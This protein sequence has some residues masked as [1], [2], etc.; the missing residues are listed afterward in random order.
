VLFLESGQEGIA[1]SD[2]DY[3]AHHQWAWIT[4]RPL[5]FMVPHF[6]VWGVLFCF[7]FYPIFGRPRTTYN[8]RF[9]SI[10]DHV[11]ASARLLR[12]YRSIDQVRSDVRKYLD[13]GDATVKFRQDSIAEKAT[14]LSTSAESSEN[15]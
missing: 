3:D 14:K 1:V 9:R 11:A 12:R 8:D 13:S 10:G 15:I 6:L 5:C 7:T 4:K 2:S